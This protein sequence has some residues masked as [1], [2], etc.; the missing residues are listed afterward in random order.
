MVKIKYRYNTNCHNFIGIMVEIS[1]SIQCGNPQMDQ[2][3]NRPKFPYRDTVM[4]SRLFKLC[5]YIYIYIYI[6][7]TPFYM[8][9]L[10]V[11]HI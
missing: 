7:K 9:K 6:Y 11:Q 10:T 5:I 2:H 1:I 4:T 8:A 3:P